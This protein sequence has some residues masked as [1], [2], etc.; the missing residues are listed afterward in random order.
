MGPRV[1]L[2][3]DLGTRTGF[4]WQAGAGPVQ[5]GTWDHSPRSGAGSGRRYLSLQTRLDA[6]RYQAGA[7]FAVGYEAVQFAP[8]DQA[9][10]TMVSA[11][12]VWAGYEAILTAWC[13]RYGVLYLPVH[14][15]TLKKFGAGT[16]RASKEQMKEAFKSLRG[17]SAIDDNEADAFHVMRWVQSKQRKSE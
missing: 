15:A 4:S 7:I 10:N 9:G 17:R 6:L 3:L 5:S 14:T 12:H 2:G 16:G 13:E 1:F 11:M 8:K